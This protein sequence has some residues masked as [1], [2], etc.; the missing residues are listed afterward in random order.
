MKNILYFVLAMALL[1]VLSESCT[2]GNGSTEE[3]GKH[4][5]TTTYR[6]LVI[7]PIQGSDTSIHLTSV[8]DLVSG[9]NTGDTVCR[10]WHDDGQDYFQYVVVR[11]VV[12]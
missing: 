7:T 12:K 11:S 5:S 6:V 2:I 3:P 8:V 1:C 9:L 4:K 10:M